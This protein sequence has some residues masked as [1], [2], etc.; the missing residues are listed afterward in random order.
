VIA[1]H[2]RA[3][4]LRD[5][6][7]L[8]GGSEVICAGRSMEP[9]VRP[10]DRVRVRACD[11]VRSGDVALFE[12][13]DSETYLLHRVVFRVP[14]TD[15]VAHIGDAGTDYPRFARLSRV[16]GRADLPRRP[17]RTRTYR[18]AVGVLARAAVRRLRRRLGRRQ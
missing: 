8:P 10:G 9:T 1:Y 17:L 14:G 4:L 7:R 11:R 3:A 18:A 16:V 15:W 12:C 5:V 6:T 2:D 13:P